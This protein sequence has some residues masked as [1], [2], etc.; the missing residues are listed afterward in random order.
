MSRSASPATFLTAEESNR[1]AAAVTE[2]ERNTSAEIKVVTVR[3]SWN[4]IHVKAAR[5]FKKLGLHKHKDRSGVL[6]LIVTTNREFL[7][8]G[9]QGIHEKVRQE[10][11]DDVRNEMQARFAEDRFADG[12]VAGIQKIG[13]KLAAHFPRRPGD[14]NEISDKV[15]H[16]N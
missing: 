14:R 15:T 13:E 8:Y 12:L 3:H 7:I 1:V 11:W 16:E 2:A 6:I 9:D 5:T 10:F 4:R